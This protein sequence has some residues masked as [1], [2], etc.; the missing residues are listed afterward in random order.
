M[1]MA[2]TDRADL[3]KLIAA[4]LLRYTTTHYPD[5]DAPTAW[6]A[7]V[8]AAADL[9]ETVRARNRER[10]FTDAA[11][12]RVSANPWQVEYD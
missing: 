7:L 12:P 1:R 9:R 4:E 5:V 11:L 2:A 6:R 3:A 8:L 10:G